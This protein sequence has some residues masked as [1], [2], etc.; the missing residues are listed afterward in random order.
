M[1]EMAETVIREAVAVLI[2][3]RSMKLS[4][5]VWTQR[6]Y[7]KALDRCGGR[8]GC[9]K[10][11][12]TKTSRVPV[13][14]RPPTRL[15]PDIVMRKFNEWFDWY[16]GICSLILRHHNPDA[17]PKASLSTQTPTLRSRFTPVLLITSKTISL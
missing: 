15:F 11:P 3:I 14:S 12:R 16:L 17:I 13:S 1:S 7:T 8:A 10:S 2:V 6:M 5:E 4:N 9:H